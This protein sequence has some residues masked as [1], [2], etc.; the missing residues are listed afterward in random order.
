MLIAYTNIN[1]EDMRKLMTIFGLALGSLL[2]SQ[3]TYA[4]E[5]APDQNPNYRVS[6][7]KYMAQ[8]DSLTATLSTTVQDTYKAYDWYEAKMERKAQKKQWRHEERMARAKYG[9]SYYSYDN[10]YYGNYNSYYS[11]W[12]NWNTWRPNIGFRTGNWWFSI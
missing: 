5:L 2:F 4:Q 10:G 6:M 8:K 7:V 11:G 9:R 1:I 12:N 3:A